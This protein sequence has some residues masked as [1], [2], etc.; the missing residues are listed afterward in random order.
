MDTVMD[1]DV[2]MAY[3]SHVPSLRRSPL[4]RLDR[5]CEERMSTEEGNSILPPGLEDGPERTAPPPPPGY[6]EENLLP[7]KRLLQRKKRGKAA[8]DHVRKSPQG[9]FWKPPPPPDSVAAVMSIV[10]ALDDLPAEPAGRAR[11][12]APKIFGRSRARPMELAA[13]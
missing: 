11:K 10:D 4:G 6:G 9:S 1:M 8:A 12:F 7:K 5:N 13:T 3:C 2:D